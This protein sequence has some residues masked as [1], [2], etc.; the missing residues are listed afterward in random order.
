[1]ACDCSNIVC[2]EDC[3]CWKAKVQCKLS[4]CFPAHQGINFLDIC[5]HSGYFGHTCSYDNSRHYSV[6]FYLHAYGLGNASDC[7][8]F[9]AC[10]KESWFL[11]ISSNTCSWI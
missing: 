5:V 1:M 8:S 2:N 9:E 11:G 3:I 7:S 10:C 6:Y 4:A